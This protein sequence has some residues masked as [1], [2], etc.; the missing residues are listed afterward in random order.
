MVDDSGC[1]A[2]EVGWCADLL[3]T[4]VSE[5]VAEAVELLLEE[6]SQRL[7]SY[8]STGD[9]S[10]ACEYYSISTGFVDVLQNR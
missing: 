1:G 5:D 4:E 9:S 10:S 7:Y 2:R 3:V 6:R 8:I